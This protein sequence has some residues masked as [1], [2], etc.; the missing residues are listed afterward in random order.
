MKLLNIHLIAEGTLVHG[1]DV[2][3]GL[4]VLP[5]EGGALHDPANV[6]PVEKTFVG[7]VNSDL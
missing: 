3:D 5:E 6:T 4:Q 2:V 1:P 7:L